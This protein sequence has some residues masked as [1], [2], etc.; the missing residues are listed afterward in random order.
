MTYKS[1]LSRKI[2]Y[3]LVY[4]EHKKYVD[5]LHSHMLFWCKENTGRII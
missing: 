1:F 3:M 4:D 2:S 5:H